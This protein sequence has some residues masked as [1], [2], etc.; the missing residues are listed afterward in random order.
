MRTVE[1]KVIETDP[2]EFCIVAQDTVIHTGAYSTLYPFFLSKVFSSRGWSCNE[3]KQIS[4]MLVMM[5]SVDA[6]NRWLRFASLLSFLCAIHSY[7]SLLVSSLHEVFSCSVLLEQERLWWLVRL[8]MKPKLS[9]SQSTVQKLWV[10]W[11]ESVR[12]ISTRLSRKLK[13]IHPPSS[14]SHR[15]VKRYCHFIY[16]W[17]NWLVLSGP[18][19]CMACM[20]SFL[21]TY[22]DINTGIYNLFDTIIPL[23]A[24]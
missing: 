22:M 5:T 12:A 8:W 21:I 2:L 11:L 20:S 3:K 4:M 17:R 16:V 18:L 14:S 15:S 23:H 1:F 7:S 9:S 6:E 13:I 24:L 19:L 10:K